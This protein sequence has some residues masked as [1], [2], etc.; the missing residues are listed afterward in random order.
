MMMLIIGLLPSFCLAYTPVP[1]DQLVLGIKNGSF[2]AVDKDNKVVA[3]WA[4]GNMATVSGIKIGDTLTD[5]NNAYGESVFTGNGYHE[6]WAQNGKQLLW[7]RINRVG[8]ILEISLL[9]ELIE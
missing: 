1:D 6:V 7:F 5:L 9:K 8:F 3:V 4:S 2:V